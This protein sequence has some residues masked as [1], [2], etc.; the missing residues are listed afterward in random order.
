M[1]INFPTGLYKSRF[2]W[3]TG[4]DSNNM[5]HNAT[6]YISSAHPPILTDRFTQITKNHERERL[7]NKVHSM[8]QRRR[9]AGSLAFTI[10]QANNREVGSTVKQFEE[11][12]VL[13]S[14]DL[15]L[16]NQLD[17]TSSN[18]ME[19]RH[20]NNVLDLDNLNNLDVNK[21]ELITKS[22]EAIKIYTEQLNTVR[23][24]I[25]DIDLQ[26]REIQKQM[27]ELNK[28]RDAVHLVDPDSE[29]SIQGAINNLQDSM[30]AKVGDHNEKSGEVEEL[31]DKIRSVSQLVR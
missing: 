20:D 21:E 31:K 23:S 7:P 26:I 18:S 22:E 5:A 3:V 4:V 9:D 28:I 15:V 25:M 16:I 11:G 6:W 17:V 27:N 8:P 14:Q 2:S 1:I 10:R 19:L 30:D 12:Q 13:E 29:S 24:E